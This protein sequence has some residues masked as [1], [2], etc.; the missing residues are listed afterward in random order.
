[1]VS[2]GTTLIMI[3]AMHAFFHLIP[4]TILTASANG[5]EYISRVF[6]EILPKEDSS[7]IV[8][9][10]PQTNET[11]NFLMIVGCIILV[12]V[13]YSYFKNRRKGT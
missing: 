8:S 2:K 3:C 9:R 13:L 6:I 10:L 4:T 12:Y 5:R 1:M 11:T 7:E